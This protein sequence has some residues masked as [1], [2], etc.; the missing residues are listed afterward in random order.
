MNIP[1]LIRNN[2]LVSI[3]YK[4]KNNLC[5]VSWKCSNRFLLDYF[6]PFKFSQSKQILMT[7]TMS[8][9]TF[10]ILK[11]VLE[12]KWVM[13]GISFWLYQKTYTY[14]LKSILC[15]W[16]AF[17]CMCAKFNKRL[18]VANT[19]TFESYSNIRHLRPKAISTET[20]NAIWRNAWLAG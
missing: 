5:K 1:G 15:Y 20:G 18:S 2:N 7:K 8:Y 13:N 3:I 9:D 4:Y 19:E 17:L 11:Y 16:I 14:V 10:S 6:K 12:V